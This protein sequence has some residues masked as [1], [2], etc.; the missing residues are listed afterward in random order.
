MFIHLHDMYSCVQQAISIFL[1]SNLH[2][3][4]KQKVKNKNSRS[5]EHFS[6]V[7]KNYNCTESLHN[8]VTTL[9]PLSVQPQR[10]ISTYVSPSCMS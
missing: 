3:L 5:K 8:E 1:E 4:F 2:F 9:M 7:Y 10:L 6:R